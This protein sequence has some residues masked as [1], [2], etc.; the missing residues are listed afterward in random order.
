MSHSKFTEN[1]NEWYDFLLDTNSSM[2]IWSSGMQCCTSQVE[3][4]E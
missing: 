4:K 2:F 3:I 1:N